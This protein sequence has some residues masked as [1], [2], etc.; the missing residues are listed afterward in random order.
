MNI[1]LVINKNKCQQGEIDRIHRSLVEFKCTTVF[2]PEDAELI[3]VLGGDGT[4]IDTARK[5]A[6]LGV[7]IAGINFGKL[8]YLATFT[9]ESFRVFLRLA[10]APEFEIV[11]SKRMMLH[12]H[13]MDMDKE[14]NHIAVND[15]VIDI[16]PPFRTTELQIEINGY[17]FATIRGDGIIIATPTGSTAYNMSAGGPI[18]QPE[19]SGITL[20]PKNPHRLSIRSIVVASDTDITISV[21]QPE[22]VFVIID[23]QVVIPMES[24]G[25]VTVR[26][27]EHSMKL[28]QSANYW[29]T[30][31]QKL[32]WGK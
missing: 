13:G 17:Q 25:K 21:P 26:R 1:C 30:L 15:C 28:V 24:K 2:E 12:V 31:T 7:P 22:G 6:H 5:V 19:L 29:E 14:W 8:G 16:G 9:S 18:V 20:T 23:G 10:T 27:A 4:I 11:P 3:V 32:N